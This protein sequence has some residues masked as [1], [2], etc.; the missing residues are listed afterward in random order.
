LDHFVKHD[1]HCRAYDRYADDSLLFHDDKAMLH[2][3]RMEMIAFLATL[4]LRLHESRAAV[5]P[6]RDGFDFLG[7][8]VFPYYRR[9]RKANA[10]AFG[11]RLREMA[12]R[13]A[14]GELTAEEIRERVRSWV[15]H[16]SFGNTYRLRTRIF[17]NVLFPR[18]NNAEFTGNSE[19]VRSDRVADSA[20]AEISQEPALCDGETCGGQ[21]AE[22]LR[23]VDPREQ[24]QR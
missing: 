4:R 14:A 6:T 11:R 10:R 2:A 12:E 13:Y 23:A 9:L 21:R 22:S 15:A 16:A 3:W 20:H 18:G 19:N 24:V 7:F 5:F 17:R 8:R 1:L